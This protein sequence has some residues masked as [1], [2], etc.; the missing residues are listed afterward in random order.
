[1][2]SHSYNITPEQYMEILT[3]LVE[4]SEPYSIDIHETITAD[5]DPF[6]HY[7]GKCHLYVW[8]WIKYN[9]ELKPQSG[10]YECPIWGVRQHWWAINE[11]GMVFDPTSMQFPSNGMGEYIPLHKADIP[12]CECGDVVPPFKIGFWHHNHMVCSD[13]C[14][15]SL[16]GY[17]SP[18]TEPIEYDE[19][20][21]WKAFVERI[22][23]KVRI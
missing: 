15:G 12:C 4:S 11:I 14:Y 7:A 6:H 1:M 8:E 13:E 22:T 17:G 10:F 20:A 21:E 5:M 16:V 9:P 2:L 19:E 18:R 23:G 3:G